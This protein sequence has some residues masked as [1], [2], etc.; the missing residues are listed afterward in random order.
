MVLGARRHK[1]IVFV[2]NVRTVPLKCC[3]RYLLDISAVKTVGTV[4]VVLFGIDPSW[5]DCPSTAQ[6]FCHGVQNWKR[7]TVLIV[8]YSL[9]YGDFCT[10][11]ISDACTSTT[12]SCL[13]PIP[14]FLYSC[15]CAIVTYCLFWILKVLLVQCCCKVQ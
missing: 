5:N 14:L 15:E 6:G 3:S 7:M 11:C 2:I 10:E 4:L 9:Y 8:M 12:K 13:W 1:Y